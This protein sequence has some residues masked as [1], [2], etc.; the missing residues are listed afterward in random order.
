MGYLLA[1]NR[2]PFL[3]TSDRSDRD[4]YTA[5]FPDDLDRPPAAFPHLAFLFSKVSGRTHPM[6]L[7]HVGVVFKRGHRVTDR[8]QSLMIT[9][10]CEL[11][12]P[13]ST[14]TLQRALRKPHSD[15]VAAAIGER[16]GVLTQAADDAIVDAIAR[17]LPEFESTLLRLRRLRRE[18]V[19][20]AGA[21]RW[22]LGLDAIR[23]A[24]RL[25]DFDTRQLRSWQVPDDPTASVL[26]GIKKTSEKDLIAHD[27]EVLPG[28]TPQRRQDT[29]VRIFSD[30]KRHM[31][32]VNADLEEPE[33]VLG[34][35]LIYYHVE[36]KS[37]VLVQ[38]KK[39]EDQKEVRVNSHLES[40]L[41]RM[42]QLSEFG[43]EPQSH[44]EWRL[45]KDFCYLKLCRTKTASGE[46]DPNNAELLPGLYLPLSYVRLALLDERVNGPRG[47]RYLGYD[48]VERYLTNTLFID[49]AKEGWIGST[50]ITAEKLV[51]I[52][53]EAPRSGHDLI[54]AIDLSPE[55][56]RERMQRQ[57]KRVP[58]SKRT[59]QTNNAQPT[60]F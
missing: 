59:G 51:Q 3:V 16:D 57:R 38:Y 8:E 39:M 31:H 28:W 35:D 36:A 6:M 14:S 18:P 12:K 34:A 30:G 56:P 32:V 26:A 43:S 41:D 21:D 42:E 2:L 7:T 44:A 4:S 17:L 45:G 23:I 58:A 15:T 27:L 1:R 48:R 60:L 5:A 22:E 40:Q 24:L 55:T 9:N 37:G 52:V 20:S 11:P 46:I 29:H 25:G 13:I 19:R 53:T 54:A 10:V 33:R 49:L 47:G 50:G